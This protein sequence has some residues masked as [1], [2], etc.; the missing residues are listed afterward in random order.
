MIGIKVK[1]VSGY[2][3]ERVLTN[4][5]FAGYL[6]TSDEWITSRTGIKR[7]HAAQDETTWQMGAKAAAEALKKAQVEAGE[8]ELI[9]GT[10]FTSDYSTP[11]MACL[12][13]KAIGAEHAFAFDISAACTGF[14]YALD[15]AAL[16]IK[17]GRV[18]RAMVVSA[19]RISKVL[20]YQD[21]STCVLFGDGAG[22]MVLEA[23]EG[24]ADI[25]ACLHST[26]DEKEVL[27]CPLYDEKN[28]LD[29]GTA[30]ATATGVKMNGRE[31][32]KFAVNAL[33]HSVEEVLEKANLSKEDIAWFVPHQANERI[34]K[35][36]AQKLDVP[37]EKMAMT[38]EEYGNTSSASIPLTL[39]K[40]D[41]EGLLHPG[42][43]LV[44]TGFGAGLTYGA[45]V[46]TW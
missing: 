30:G 19:E 7:R 10:T 20:D 44:L 23:E 39:A 42:D 35:S 46:I 34:V 38:I 28:P 21:R 33:A 14:V 15:L 25:P 27:Y 3:P 16:Y 31:V 26:I 8:I 17:T 1:A 12:V 45:V 32:Y 5:Y 18:K 40:L 22:A 13:Q 29:G 24:G 9:I 11:S 43:K 37:M 41:R 36:A 2:A 4:D 6:E